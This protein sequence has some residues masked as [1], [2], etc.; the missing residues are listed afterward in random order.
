MEKIFKIKL[1][2]LLVIFL[3][4]FWSFIIA[5]NNIRFAVIGD[6]GDNSSAEA[7]V[8][9]LVNSWNVDFIITVGDNNYPGGEAST[10]DENIGQYYHQYIYPYTGNY[11]DGS[12]VN[13][14]FPSLGNHDW[15]TNPPQPY[16]DYFE[17]PN[18]ERYYDFV[19]GNVHFFA[20]D[21]DSD[22]PDGVKENSVQGQWL[23]NAMAL[24]TAKWQVVYFH[25]SPYSSCSHHGSQEYMQ[26]PFNE[27]GAS[28]V[29]SGHDHVYERL[30]VNGLP[31]FVNGLGGDSKYSFG[32]PV[33]GSEVRYNDD[34]GAMLVEANLDS[35]TFK[36]YSRDYVLVDSYT[37]HSPVTDVK[38][39]SVNTFKLEQNY[40]NPF[41]PK[42]NIR[43]T[44]SNKQFVSL[45]IYDIIGK[46]VAT[47]V[48]QEKPA[49]TYE[50]EFTS[51]NLSSG[52]YYYKL[53]VGDIVQT[54]KMILMR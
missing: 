17:L 38:N 24:S 29:F 36:F 16:Y 50:V 45:K 54:K 44:I 2:A 30:I 27:W 4:G 41:N 42:T 13:R 33:T 22:E 21:S 32:S 9:N 3:S 10:I 23:K 12:N 25:H 53:Q 43:Y 46:K 51:R 20:I 15:H 49:G 8:A 28:V 1:I 14:F 19:R 48:N 18:N 7:D 34:Y 31:Y 39:A 11:G 40:P 37:L 26:W 47:L 35:M 5:Q 6:Y 52:I